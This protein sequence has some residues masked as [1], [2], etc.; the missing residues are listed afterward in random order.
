MLLK[1]IRIVLIVFFVL[2]AI[3]A[4]SLAVWHYTHDDISPPVFTSDDDLLLVSA[5]VTDKELCAG[6]HA[7]D[8]MD[9]DIS[10][11]ILVKSI[12]PLINA[13]D[14]IVSYLVFD[15]ASN[16]ASYSRTIRYTDYHVPHFA[17]SQ[18]LTYAVGDKITLLDRLTAEDV[19]EGDISNRI[20]LTQS[21]VSNSV[22][23]A[24]PISVQVTNSAGDTAILPLTITVNALSASTPTL[25]LTDY[26]LYVRQGETLNWRSY[27]GT[28]RDP[29]TGSGNRNSVICNSDNVDL[30]K[31]GVY[32]V[33]YYYT[34]KSGETATA[35]LTVVVE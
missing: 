20:V 5:S 8:N 34:G 1:T 18:P 25:R 11:R 28:V 35:I 7:Y 9:G 14:A 19:I 3:A 4:G 33:Y 22:V 30:D 10:D 12:S 24:Y 6:L 32:E 15:E 31:L 23:G 21:N 27:I 16:A 2:G 13:T 29:L 17:L 26:L